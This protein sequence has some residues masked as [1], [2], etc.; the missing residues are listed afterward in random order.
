M[1]NDRLHHREYTVSGPLY[2]AMTTTA[3]AGVSVVTSF[4]YDPLTTTFSRPQDCNGIYKPEYLYM[5]DASST[6]LPTGFKTDAYFSPGLICPAGYYSACHDNT[7]V[8]SFTTVTCSPVLNM[9]DITFSCVTTTT[10]TGVWTTLYC[11]WVADSTRLLVTQSSNGVTS[12]VKE[13]FRSPGGLNAYGVRMVHQS[14]DLIATTSATA[15]APATATVSI[16]QSALPAQTAAVLSGGL[17]VGAKIAIAVVPSVFALAMLAGMLFLWRRR[18]RRSG[19]EGEYGEKRW[20]DLQERR[21]SEL[22]GGILAPTE[23]AADERFV[24]R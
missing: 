17:S 1:L 9:L 20:T 6:C 4:A 22:P 5:V 13:E 2:L 21:E 10:R 8:P 23:L 16:T 15:T 19:S 11:T 24:Y 3:A 14:T 7:G 18:K 12:T